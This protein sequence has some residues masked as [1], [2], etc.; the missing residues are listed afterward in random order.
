[1]RSAFAKAIWG[2][3]CQPFPYRVG[4]KDL[5]QVVLDLHSPHG[6]PPQRGENVSNFVSFHF[7]LTALF[8]MLIRFA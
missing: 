5:P 1:M 2:R 6:I 8:R 3:N 7:D 4:R